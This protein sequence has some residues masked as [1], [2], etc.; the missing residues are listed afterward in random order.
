MIIV[1]CLQNQIFFTFPFFN[2]YS[3]HITARTCIARFTVKKRY[4]L[5]GI[6]E[7]Q[8][9]FKHTQKFIKLSVLSAKQLLR[10]RFLEPFSN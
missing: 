5:L 1:V 9:C 2:F 3:L 7:L 6:F 4:N 10:K 8:M